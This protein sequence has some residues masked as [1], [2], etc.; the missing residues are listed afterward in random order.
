M[1]STTKSNKTAQNNAPAAQAPREDSGPAFRVLPTRYEVFTIR[2]RDLSGRTLEKP[3]WTKIGVAFVNRDGKGIN[4]H[5]D[6]LP[7]DGKLTLRLPMPRE[8]REPGSDG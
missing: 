2:D 6:S 7:L 5:L 4:V 3:F 8:D 1:A